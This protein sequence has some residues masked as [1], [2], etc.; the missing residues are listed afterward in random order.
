MDIGLEQSGFDTI[1]NIDFDKDCIATLKANKTIG[2]NKAIWEL[3]LNGL[4]N[5]WDRKFFE[6]SAEA[7]LVSGG[8]PCQSFSTVGKEQGLKDSRGNEVNNYLNIVEMIK[9]RFFILENVR[10]MTYAKTKE[11]FNLVKVIALQARIMGYSVAR[12]FLN[13]LDYGS[14]QKRERF[15]MVGSRDNEFE[16]DIN[17]KELVKPTQ[18]TYKTLY[19]AIGDI[20]N[21]PGEY[22]RYSPRRKEL[23]KRVPPGK[24]WRWIRDS[25]QYSEED[26]IEMMGGAYYQSGGKTGYWRRLSFDKPS[27]TVTTSPVQ[28][29][30]G[31]CHPIE[32]RP[33]S[34]KEYARVQ[35]FP[36][37][38][39]FEGTLASQYKQ[40]G[41]AVPIELARAIGTALQELI[42]NNDR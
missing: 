5:N 22:I 21:D 28:K 37:D 35:G 27:P 42:D 30:T 13:A 7:T 40:I 9:P 17:I 10:G 12:G 3:D 19:D 32:D 18:E 25:D 33:L 14:S 16:N 6:F 20:Q 1:V 41:N 29:A 23:Y 31:L 26:L 11:G 4:N 15:I 34:V 8:P 36:D 2:A 39:K 24:N 38:W